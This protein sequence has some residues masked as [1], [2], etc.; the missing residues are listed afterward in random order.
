MFPNNNR[1]VK[2]NEIIKKNVLLVLYNLGGPGDV[3]EVDEVLL[4]KRKH[5]VGRIPVGNYW[6]FGGVSRATKKK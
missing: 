1:K 2:L 3:V 5:N 6:V 4:V